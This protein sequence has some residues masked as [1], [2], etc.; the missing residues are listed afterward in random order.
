ME[1]RDCCEV[2]TKML[3]TIPEEKTELIKDLQSN[4]ENA[5]YNTMQWQRT[6][7]TLTKH[8]PV[9]TEDWEFEMLS[10]L[11]TKSIEEIKEMFNN[12]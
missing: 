2:I 6:V 10:I 4:F 5:G 12:K 1:R 8:I 11:T 7:Q 3:D 9:P